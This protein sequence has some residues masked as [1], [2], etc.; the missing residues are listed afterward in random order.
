M[1]FFTLAGNILW[2]YVLPGIPSF[3]MLVAQ[4]WNQPCNTVQPALSN[5]SF[6]FFKITV[7]MIIFFSLTLFVMSTNLVPKRKCQKKL[8]EAYLKIRAPQAKLIYLY[9]RPHSAQFYSRGKAVLI[10]NLD[11]TKELFQNEQRDYFV[12]RKKHLNQLSDQFSAKLENL[13]EYNDYYLLIER[14]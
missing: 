6:N 10:D 9:K 14:P 13:G 7:G 3:A 2:T 12:I 11:K 1:V 4:L 5:R 8:I